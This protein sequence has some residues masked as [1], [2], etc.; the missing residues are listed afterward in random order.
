MFSFSFGPTSLD[1]QLKTLG[2]TD[3]YAV[4]LE[5][6]AAYAATLAAGNLLPFAR[7]AP[8]GDD[9]ADIKKVA[10]HITANFKNLIV[11]GTGGSSLGAQAAVALAR[12]ADGRGTSIHTPDSLDPFEMDLLFKSIDPRDS[13]IL[14]ISKSG[15][16]GETLAQLLACRA[17]LEASGISRS[18]ADHFS[19]VT[20]PGP[21]PMRT[22]AE[23][24]GSPVM[25][26]PTDV[27]GR[28]SVLTNVGML[29]VA[30][31]GLSVEGFR[32]GSNQVCD[33]FVADP[34]NAAAVVGAALIQTLSE[35]KGIT[36]VMIMPYA[37]SLRAFT[38]WHGQ[39]W[40]E[41]VGKNGLGTTP[42]RAVGPV[43]QHS[44]LQLFLD[45]PNDKFC[46]IITVPSYD[47]G[48]RIDTAE[49]K[50]YGL[51]YMAGRTIGDMVTCQSRATQDALRAKGR[52]VREIV[53]GELCEENLG[54]LF[55]SYMLE[56][57][58]TAHLMGVDA[59]DQP[60]VE[61]GKILTRQYLGELNN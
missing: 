7:Q 8:D 61:Q 57:V 10:D 23:K 25:D 40:A 54:G 28:F 17:W 4:N 43:D 58:I 50:A 45:G 33:A 24:L 31:S 26:H 38:R 19:F 36:Q 20:E 52:T 32:R 56:T 1:S 2:L 60:A 39:L 42:I 34:S 18:L 30:V 13:H 37:E 12:F 44:Q 5:K 14:A 9:M 27:G 51:D 6:A 48:P 47:K 16:T 35:H 29:P 59:F 15:T 46:T 11:L 3:A 49:A 41:S 22:Y 55:V 53:I 21:R